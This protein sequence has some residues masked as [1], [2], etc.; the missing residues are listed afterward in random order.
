MGFS[1]KTAKEFFH[2][3]LRH[4]LDTEDEELIKEVTEKASL[5]GYSR[6]IR[7]YHNKKSISDEDKDK[8]KLYTARISEI[9]SRYDTLVLT[10]R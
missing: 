4:Y 2:S 3:F 6:L 10:P 7:K 9:V 1:A 8:I 5:I